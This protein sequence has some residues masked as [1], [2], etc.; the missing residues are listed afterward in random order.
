[1]RVALLSTPHY[2][3][4]P[5][6]QGGSEQVAALLAAGL[7]RRG[8][9]VVLAGHPGRGP[10]ARPAGPCPDGHDAPPPPPAGAP[11]P[12]APLVAIDVARQCGSRLVLAGPHGSFHGTEEFFAT[13]IRPHLD[14]RI[15][16]VGEVAGRE[17]V[18][19]LARARCLLLPLRWDEP[20]GLV[21]RPVA[22]HLHGRPRISGSG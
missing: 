14:G 4:P 20:F 10:C 7:T 18:E 15:T 8:H 6:G 5:G 22:L 3:T 16:D 19:L 17:K 12:R 21:E 13:R 9:E 11:L 2:P 1:M